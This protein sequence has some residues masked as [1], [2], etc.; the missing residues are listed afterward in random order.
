MKLYG[1]PDSGHVFKVKFCL[2]AADIVHQ[3]EVIDIFSDR[4]E[5]NPEFVSK[6][7]FCEVP[8]LVDG[9]KSLI[10]SNAI[11]VYIASKY[12]IYGGESSA[13]LQACLEWLIWEANKIGMCLPQL[14]ADKKFKGFELADGASAWLY[15]R[16]V[17]DV[18]V[19]EDQLNDGRQFILGKEVTI[20]DFSLCG[21]LMYAEEAQVRVPIN[22]SSWIN[23]LKALNGWANPYDMLRDPQTRFS[24]SKLTS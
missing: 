3:Y 5:R 24:K 11:L 19:I 21:Y 16:Y 10:Q 1:H 18:G 22:V 17:H 8:L 7:R 4:S 15:D 12:Q 13:K 20:A 9:E 2:Q 14:R 6:S 23:R